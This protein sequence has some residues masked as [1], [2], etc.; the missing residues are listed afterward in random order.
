MVWG[1]VAASQDRVAPSQPKT[2][3][4]N[5]LQMYKV[6]AS[7]VGAGENYYH[8]LADEMPSRGYAIRPIFNW[9]LPTLTVLNANLPSL[10]TRSLL[11]LIGFSSVPLWLS[12]LVK[13]NARALIP[14]IMALVLGLAI[15]SADFARF[16]HETWAGALISLS[17]ALRAT[18]RVGASVVAAGAALFIRELTGPYVVI[19][20]VVAAT[21]R[22]RS[23]ALGWTAAL[24]AFA[25]FWLWHASQVLDVMPREGLTNSWNALGGWPFVLATTHANLA[26]ALFPQ[27]LV[28][29][30]IPLIWAGP[31]YW[32]DATGRRMAAVLT[33]YFVLFMFFGRPDNWDWGLTVAPLV[34]IAPFGYFHPSRDMDSNANGYRRTLPKGGFATMR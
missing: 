26:I 11:L 20:L 16:F 28:A 10:V 30:V 15:L 24:T 8:V 32:R 4:Q 31:F 9:R 23:E 22:R 14:G 1:L 21:E 17:L 27:W 2:R 29:I 25:A 33:S 3:S 6:F 7:R 13:L 12:V 5:D 18:G 19:M 34:T